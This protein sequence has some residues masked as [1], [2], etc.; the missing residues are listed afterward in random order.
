VKAARE[1]A[2]EEGVEKLKQ[3]V[4]EAKEQG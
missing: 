3:A 4:K 1:K 2:E